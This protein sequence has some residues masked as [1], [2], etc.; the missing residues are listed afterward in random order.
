MAIHQS[1]ENNLSYP[2]L[3]EASLRAYRKFRLVED[4]PGGANFQNGASFSWIVIEQFDSG[5]KPTVTGTTGTSVSSTKT[6]ISST[7]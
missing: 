5:G 1:Q 2:L 4:E 3:T 6:T 7:S